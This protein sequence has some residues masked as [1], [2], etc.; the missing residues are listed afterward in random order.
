MLQ[1]QRFDDLGLCKIV[2]SV[3]NKQ[4][5]P[6]A[7]GLKKARYSAKTKKKHTSFSDSEV[8]R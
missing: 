7:Y 5:S 4:H 2:Y 8:M 6:R 3:M 1:E